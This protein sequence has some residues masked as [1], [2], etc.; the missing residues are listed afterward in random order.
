MVEQIVKHVFA[1]KIY[2][3]CMYRIFEMLRAKVFWRKL[4]ISST[5]HFPFHTFQRKLNGPLQQP[6]IGEHFSGS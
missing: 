4:S 5:I 1:V 2:N 3:F 6:T